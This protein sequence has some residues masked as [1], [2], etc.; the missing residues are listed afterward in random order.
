MM[1]PTTI[2]GALIG[3][4]ANKVRSCADTSSK[5][6]LVH[7]PY[8]FGQTAGS[9]RTAG[10]KAGC[11][12]CWCRVAKR[13]VCS[14]AELCWWQSVPLRTRCRGLCN[15]QTVQGWWLQ[16][17]GS[18]YIPFFPPLPS[19]AL[20]QYTPGAPLLSTTANE[21]AIVPSACCCRSSPTGS[22]PLPWACAANKHAQSGFDQQDSN[23][24]CCLTACLRCRLT[25]L[26]VS[27]CC[28]SS[29][30]GSPPTS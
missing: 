12:D 27:C 3:A 14:L 1:E 4:V 2:A 24:A 17:S 9:R 15:S 28:R 18:V 16:R 11:A 25:P 29:P 20:P 21:P 22:P 26:P 30:T 6:S 7:S 23:L 5:H 8:P 19:V 10:G 13:S